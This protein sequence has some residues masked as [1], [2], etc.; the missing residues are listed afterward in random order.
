MSRMTLVDMG[1]FGRKNKKKKEKKKKLGD[2][3]QK[4]KKGEKT[5]E[6]EGKE[7]EFQGNWKKR[8]KRQKQDEATG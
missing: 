6:L 1:I 2:Y 3:G 7:E 4:R 8:L 5:R